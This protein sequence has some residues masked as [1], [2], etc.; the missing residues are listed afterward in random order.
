VAARHDEQVA[1]VRARV[2]YHLLERWVMKGRG[3]SVLQEKTMGNFDVAAELA[4]DETPGTHGR[5]SS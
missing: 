4:A 5:S 3:R 2:T 1:E